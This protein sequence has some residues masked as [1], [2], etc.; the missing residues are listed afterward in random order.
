[1]SGFSPDSVEGLAPNATGDRLTL[2]STSGAALTATG[3]GTSAGVTATGGGTS[4]GG[5]GVIGTGGGTNARGGQFT[6]TGASSGVVG[7]GGPTDGIGVQGAGGGTNGVGGSFTAGGT[8]AA[9]VAVNT[10]PGPGLSVSGDTTSPVRAAFLLV[11]QDAEPTGAHVVG[12]IY[13]TSAG[14]LK[15]CTAA[16][17]PGTWTS[18]G[19]QV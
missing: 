6:A 14:V 2:A 11:P 5:V 18:V 3:Q 7:Q 16:G 12:H 15:I 17:T 13:V 10:G 4:T 8:G 9:V 1:M 19:A